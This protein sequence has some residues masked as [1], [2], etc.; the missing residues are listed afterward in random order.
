MTGPSQARTG[1]HHGSDTPRDRR[2]ERTCRVT[3]VTRGSVTQVT[4]G[5]AHMRGT[6]AAHAPLLRDARR[7][8]DGRDAPRLRAHLRVSKR[9]RPV[10]ILAPARALKRHPRTRIHRVAHERPRVRAFGAT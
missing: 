4:R 8:A 5:R 2:A 10:R 7:D 6:R 1:S 3:Q 9:V